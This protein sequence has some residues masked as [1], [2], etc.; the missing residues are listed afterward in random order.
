MLS[1]DHMDC[2]RLYAIYADM[3][4]RSFEVSSESV[5]NISSCGH[6]A[7]QD[8]SVWTLLPSTDMLTPAQRSKLYTL[9]AQAPAA[10]ATAGDLLLTASR[11]CRAASKS[12]RF[13]FRS[14]ER[15][16][17]FYLRTAL[18]FDSPPTGGD[19]SLGECIV[20]VER[21]DRQPGEEGG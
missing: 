18:Y 20:R 13:C 4:T 1:D 16:D 3:D 17:Y 15:G 9:F 12:A 19:H 10:H 11:S 8:E 7:M 5:R 21:L 2:Q 6:F 14:N